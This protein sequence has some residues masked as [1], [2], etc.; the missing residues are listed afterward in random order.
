[1]K[2]IRLYSKYYATS[3]VV[4]L[5]QHA[6]AQGS[7]IGTLGES[8]NSTV[9]EVQNSFWEPAKKIYYLCCLILGLVGA[10]KVYSKWSN[11]DPDTTKTAAGWIGS[12]IFAIAVINIIE[13]FFK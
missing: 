3:C 7:K 6:M 1:M 11:G 4:F 9:E 13:L 5:A 8:L 10:F 2:K 12:L